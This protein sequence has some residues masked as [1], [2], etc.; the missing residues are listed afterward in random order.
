[1]REH[2][3]FLLLSFPRGR[4][5]RIG[6]LLKRVEN[7]YRF[8]TP[9]FVSLWNDEWNAKAKILSLTHQQL[10]STQAE[11]NQFESASEFQH[12]YPPQQSG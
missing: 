2:Q 5:D 9:S 7:L 6:N 1:M 11:S 12:R 3:P 10:S 8:P 4:D